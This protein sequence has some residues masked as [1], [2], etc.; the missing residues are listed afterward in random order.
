MLFVHEVHHVIGRHAE[1]F[2]AGYRDGLLPALT[3]SDARLL[4]FPDENHWVLKP[5]NS[6]LWYAEFLAWLKRHDRR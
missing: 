6:K 3:S 4:W 5:R 2:E 1:D